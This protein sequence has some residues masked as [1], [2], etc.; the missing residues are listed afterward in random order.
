MIPVAA[1]PYHAGHHALVKMASSEN[2]RVILFV[3]T[4][5]RKRKGE[6]P[7]LGSDMLRVWKEHLEAIMPPNVEIEYG[8]SPVQK[9]YQALGDAEAAGSG[10][11]FTVYS[12][13]EDTALN[14]PEKNRVKY[15]P[16]LYEAGQVVFAAEENP[17][18]FTRGEG[19]PDVSGTKMLAAIASGDV[20][21]FRRGMP[22]ELEA[23]AVLDILRPK[24]MGEALLRAYIRQV[25]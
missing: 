3:S 24:T 14:Y 15:F 6:M 12:D 2:D 25:M 8:G 18:R 4:S 10:D 13:P 21:T 20:E 7:L 17:G 11:T 5:D 19:T 16:E 22:P 23:D 9:V 1:K